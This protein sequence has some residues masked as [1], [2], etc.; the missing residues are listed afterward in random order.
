MKKKVREDT[1][2]IEGARKRN[3]SAKQRY[4]RPGRCLRWDTTNTMIL[5]HK[6]SGQQ[7]RT[8][9][10][11]WRRRKGWSMAELEICI[12]T[13]DIFTFRMF[14]MLVTN[15]RS[16]V[17]KPLTGRRI[18]QFDIFHRNWSMSFK[19]TRIFLLH[20]GW[21]HTRTQSCSRIDSDHYLYTCKN[22][23]YLHIVTECALVVCWSF[24]FNTHTYA[25]KCIF[26]PVKLFFLR[27]VFVYSILLCFKSF[28][29]LLFLLSAT[30]PL[31][32]SRRS[33]ESEQL[34][35]AGDNYKWMRWHEENH[36]QVICMRMIKHESPWT[37][38]LTT[39]LRYLFIY[40]HIYVR[41]PD[42]TKITMVLILFFIAVFL[43]Y[44]ERSE[45]WKSIPH[46][47]KTVRG[48]NWGAC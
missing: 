43:I 32:Q 25:H 20:S 22:N 44:L 45:Y 47:K 1:D 15:D 12:C 28:L 11:K 37:F 35:W 9:T 34:Q 27:F 6:Q 21:I 19:V 31:S 40:T 24:N 5:L 29:L 16:P 7:R 39:R 33:N 23:I 14:V 10:K 17:E 46:T 13:H 42:V 8:V 3:N 41:S 18:L 30:L 38:C 48:T 26:L 2:A 4:C 36:T